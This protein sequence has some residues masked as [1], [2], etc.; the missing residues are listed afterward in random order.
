MKTKLPILIILLSQA[1]QSQ[2]PAPSE[3]PWSARTAASFVRQHPD[4]IAY[5]DEI[6]G[7]RW[8][9]EQGLMLEALRRV[10]ERMGDSSLFTYIRRDIDR[11]V[12]QD[13]SIRTYELES[14]NLDNVAP[15]RIL[16]YLKSRTGDP[17]YAAAA[18]LLRRQLKEQPRTRGGGFWHKQI[19]PYQ[20]WLDGIFMA[21]PFYAQYAADAGEIAAFDDI[22]HQIITIEEKTRDE[23][24]GLL[25]HGWD[26][27]RA[28][29]W[30]DAKTGRS[31]NFWGRAMGWYVMGLVDVLDSFPKTHPRRKE[32]IATLQR[33]AE[34][35]SHFQDAESGLWYQVVDKAGKE[36]NYLEASA[37]CMFAYALAKGTRM[38]YL[39]S[40]YR[41]VAE[42]AFDGI[43]KQFVT[44]DDDGIVRLHQTC[45]VAGL[46]GDPYRDGS[47][48]YYIGEPRRTN[49]F[50]GMGPFIF[51]ALEL[52]R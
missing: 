49:D 21:E 27:S 15:G 17:K 48:E 29:R 43:L 37:S 35:V 8:T 18:Q 30:S 1:C 10:G 6:R 12:G 45:Q 38:G 44:V 14:Y 33:L 47:Y 39:D 16:L 32:I 13:G 28:Q 5:P 50:K 51:A 19:Y 11:F 46:G 41:A 4:S 25:Y 26:E 20:M 2:G 34:A 36:G 23:K 24:T 52:E 31:P 22:A 9:Y 42:K 7:A 3:R 40:T